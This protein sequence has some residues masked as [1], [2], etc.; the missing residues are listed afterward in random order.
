MCFQLGRKNQVEADTVKDRILASG[1]H[2][3]TRTFQVAP[4]MSNTEH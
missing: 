3:M 2:F 1:S 4:M